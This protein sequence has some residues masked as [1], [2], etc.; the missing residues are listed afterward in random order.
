MIG[1]ISKKTDMVLHM[2]WIH[3]FDGMQ[4][5]TS[6]RLRIL[7]VCNYWSC[8]KETHSCLSCKK[9]DD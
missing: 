4:N 6:V 2:E 9:L 5:N 7:G 1:C 3:Y 8:E